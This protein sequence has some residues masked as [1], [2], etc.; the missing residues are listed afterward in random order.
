MALTQHSQADILS[1][2]LITL[3][4]G[5][6]P[7][8]GSAWPV[9]VNS[10][11][12]KPDNCITV[13]DTEGRIDGRHQPTGNVQSH[14]GVQIRVRGKDQTTARTRIAAIA[15]ALDQ[16]VYRESVTIDAIIY[17]LQSVSRTS[18]P[19]WIGKEAPPA[20]RALFTL[21]AVITVRQTN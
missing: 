11:P 6:D 1:R 16:Q 21:N 3:T 19:L 10:E 2:V 15:E 5:T 12:S 8:D 13:Y 9:N 20:Q 17:C 14:P 18:D 7:E 4:L